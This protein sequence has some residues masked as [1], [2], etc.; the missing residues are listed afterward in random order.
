MGSKRPRSPNRPPPPPQLPP[1]HKLTHSGRWSQALPSVPEQEEEE[2]PTDRGG[3]HGPEGANSTR[4]S[5]L[6]PQSREPPA[7]KQRIESDLIECVPCDKIFTEKRSLYRHQRESDAH[8]TQHK[9]PPESFSCDQCGKVYRRL[10]YLRKHIR[11]SGH[12]S[13]LFGGQPDGVHQEMRNVTQQYSSHASQPSQRSLSRPQDTNV[14]TTLLWSDSTLAFARH[15]P[16]ECYASTAYYSGVGD[17]IDSVLATYQRQTETYSQA[18]AISAAVPDL[19]SLG[20]AAASSEHDWTADQ[21]SIIN[22]GTSFSAPSN[23]MTPAASKLSPASFVIE[24]ATEAD[25]DKDDDAGLAALVDRSLNLLDVPY[26]SANPVS[27]G[28]NL[29][30]NQIRFPTPC[31]L[32][33]YEFGLGPGDD[34]D[35]EAHI[36]RHTQRM[37]AID[38][39][40]VSDSEATCTVCQIHFLD[41]RD[42]RR[43]QE[44]V[45]LR[46][47][48]SCGFAFD[49][50]ERACTGHHPPTLDGQ[51]DS[52]HR[53]FKYF[54][55]EWEDL[56]RHAFREY[57]DDYSEGM[58]PT[59]APPY[60]E[61]PRQRAFNENVEAYSKGLELTSRPPACRK[62]TGSIYWAR[63]LDSTN[64]TFSTPVRFYDGRGTKPKSLTQRLD[65]ALMDENYPYYLLVK[66]ICSESQTFYPHFISF[67]ELNSVSVEMRSSWFCPV[68]KI[69]RVRC[70]AALVEYG[71]RV[72]VS[73][74]W[75]LTSALQGAAAGP[76]LFAEDSL[77]TIHSRLVQYAFLHAVSRGQSALVSKL[78]QSGILET[79]HGMPD[80]V[81]IQ[82]LR[83]SSLRALDWIY[84]DESSTSGLIAE[85]S[86]SLGP[87]A[88]VLALIT[89]HHHAASLLI[90]HHVAPRWGISLLSTR[91]SS[92][93]SLAKKIGGFRGRRETLPHYLEVLEKLLSA[94]SAF[95]TN[96]NHHSSIDKM[97]RRRYTRQKISARNSNWSDSVTLC[98]TNLDASPTAQLFPLADCASSRPGPPLLYG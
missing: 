50:K 10:D 93:H 8:C 32:C 35:V 94:T 25:H 39:D 98:N 66:S 26:R 60:K 15:D 40:T 97:L 52:D 19:A 20:C 9:S 23:E 33:G 46:T 58:A 72:S 77:L 18:F 65:H 55:R 76:L 31:P 22:Q 56:H 96:A 79:T 88:L 91:S 38:T 1:L 47:G 61:I 37:E 84:D 89:H 21:S 7:K 85:S 54:L 62:T 74:V 45:R 5:A 27:E 28:R 68:V 78:L 41:T 6:E 30:P 80:F 70:L 36:R 57:V 4:G 82:D 42:L 51:V 44:S 14:A 92:R 24:V 17:T 63:G 67:S 13:R 81:F 59:N 86:K 43:H 29:R 69:E 48:R 95:P 75:H 3:A 64:K 83:A 87:C 12:V 2:G 34:G 53:R 71:L 49:H 90:E 16:T 11:K 73:G